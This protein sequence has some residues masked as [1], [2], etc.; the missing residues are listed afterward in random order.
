MHH[1]TGVTVFGRLEL[2]A[3]GWSSVREK[4]YW[5]TGGRRLVLEKSERNTVALEARPPAE[6]GECNVSVV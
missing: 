3:G 2:E 4:H 5:L 6:H 1:P